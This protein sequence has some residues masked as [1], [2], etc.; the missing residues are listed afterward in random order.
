MATTTAADRRPAGVGRAI[1]LG[2]AALVVLALTSI[3]VGVSAVDPVGLVRGDEAQL[4]VLWTARLP[5]TVAVVLAGAA[6]GVTGL[7]MQALTRNRFVA[8]STAGTLESATFGLLIATV[9]APGAPIGVKMA[10]AAIASLLGTGLFLWLIERIR[11]ADLVMVPL[12]GIMLGGVIMAIT[13]FVAY[14]W[15]LLQTLASWTNADFSA[16]IRG[17]YELLWLVAVVCVVAWLYAQRFTIA[18]LGREVSVNLGVDHTRTVLLGLA[19]VA[20]VTA[21]VVVVIGV[22]PFLGLVVP[23][24]VTMRHG[25]RLERVIPLTAIGGA[26]FLLAT[27]LVS[28]TIRHPFEMPVGT[29]AGVVGGTIFLSMLLRGRDG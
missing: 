22:I 23:N 16:T 26:V 14:R 27:D 24:L 13:T 2:L 25:D 21:V 29:V 1:P 28:R 4:T 5:R 10:I 17:R 19:M 3:F 15:D 7:V 6:M 8:P 20:V 9:A 18:S 12:V 11:F